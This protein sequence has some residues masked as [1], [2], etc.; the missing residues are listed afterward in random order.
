MKDRKDELFRIKQGDDESL[1]NYLD[2]FLFVQHRCGILIEKDLAKTIF[3]RGITD[4]SLDMLNLMGK[5]NVNSLPLDEI[6]KLYVNYS[7]I[8]TS[9]RKAKVQIDSGAMKTLI[10]ELANFKIDILVELNQLKG[11][12]NKIV[13]AKDNEEPLAIY[14]SKCKKKYALHECPLNK[15]E[16]CSLCNG[17]HDTNKCECLNIAQMSVVNMQAE[18]NYIAQ[19]MNPAMMNQPRFM[20]PWWNMPYQQPMGAFGP[21]MPPNQDWL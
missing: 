4:S 19:R 18:A 11:A 6:L 15:I 17:T 16:I 10:E 7:R 14:C 9:S 2:R 3:L 8:R 21:W 12:A 20:S 5:G 13:K 1:E